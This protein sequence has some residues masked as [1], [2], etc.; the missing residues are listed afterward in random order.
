MQAI[1]VQC[2]TVYY[3]YYSRA[4]PSSAVYMQLQ[5]NH[6]ARLPNNMQ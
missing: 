3:M 4:L 1:T 2:K 5:H 6:Y